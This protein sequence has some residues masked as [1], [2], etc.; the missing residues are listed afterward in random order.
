VHA[1]L[2]LMN[3]RSDFEALGADRPQGWVDMPARAVRDHVVNVAAGLGASWRTATEVRAD[4]SHAVAEIIVQVEQQRRA[5]GLAQVNAQY[6]IYRQGQVA[7]GEKAAPYSV[8]LTAFTRSLV[9]LA[10][11]NARPA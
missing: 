3:V 1:E 8:H 10:A 2:V 5:G 7:R 4:A 11:Q 9:V 6:K